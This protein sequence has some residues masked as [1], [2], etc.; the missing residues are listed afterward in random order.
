MA[1]RFTVGSGPDETTVKAQIWDTAGQ[2]KFISMMNSYYRAAKG[3]VLVYDITSK[4]SFEAVERWRKEL[5]QHTD[6]RCSLT[7]CGNKCDLTSDREVSNETANEYAQ[8][9]DMA[10]FETSAKT[11]I[12]VTDAFQDLVERKCSHHRHKTEGPSRS[13]PFMRRKRP[14]MKPNLI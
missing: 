11:N 8:M 1:K 2:E 4:K 3:V 14:P 13:P 12:N 5:T 7:L 10:F 9:R 6:E